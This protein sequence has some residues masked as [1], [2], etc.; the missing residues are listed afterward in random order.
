MK[1]DLILRE[2]KP[3]AEALNELLDQLRSGAKV[4]LEKAR[5]L[6]KTA[7]AFRSLV[8]SSLD[9]NLAKPELALIIEA[10]KPRK[11]IATN[12]EWN[13]AAPQQPAQPALA[14][15]RKPARGRTRTQ[16]KS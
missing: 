10:E 11:L 6:I 3:F 15:T 12:K 8:D 4:D 14:P 1:T 9:V 5:L 2:L 16:P 13:G 7:N